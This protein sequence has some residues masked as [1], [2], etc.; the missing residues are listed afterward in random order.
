M[1]NVFILLP[2]L[3]LTRVVG[4]QSCWSNLGLFSKTLR[5]RNIYVHTYIYI[6]IYIYIY[7]AYQ[8]PFYVTLE[9]IM[10]K[11]PMVYAT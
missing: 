7:T 5:S 2:C 6:Y 1:I 10:H 4:R 11:R 3:Y 8:F 9:F